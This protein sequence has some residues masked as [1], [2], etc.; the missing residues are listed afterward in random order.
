MVLAP[1]EVLGA[2]KTVQRGRR[3]VRC[4]DH[5]PNRVGTISLIQF[6]ASVVPEVS[7]RREPGVRQGIADVTPCG[8]RVSH[9]TLAFNLPGRV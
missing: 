5:V 4:E 8:G 6:L 3:S 2:V 1:C 7:V 9:L